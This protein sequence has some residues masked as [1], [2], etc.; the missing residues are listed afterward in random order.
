MKIETHSKMKEVN[1]IGLAL[2]EWRLVLHD[3][4]RADATDADAPNPSIMSNV[5]QCL[6]SHSIELLPSIEMYYKDPL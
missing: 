6:C 1:L 2:K 4:V 3:L 5:H